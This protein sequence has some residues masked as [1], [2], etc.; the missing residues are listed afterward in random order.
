MGWKYAQLGDRFEIG[1]RIT[2]LYA[3]VLKQSSP[4]VKDGP[5]SALSRAI[6]DA[7]MVK[8]TTSTITPLVSSMTIAG[9]VLDTLYSSR[10][11]SDAGRLVTMMESHL[12]LT[13][14]L[15]VSKDHIMP[16]TEPSLLE[17]ALCAKVGGSVAT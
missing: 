11:I 3:D 4:F 14:V 8:A 16:S 6:S 9:S 7:F 2:N 1:R 10:R 15:L 13:R 5:F 17:Q 12:E